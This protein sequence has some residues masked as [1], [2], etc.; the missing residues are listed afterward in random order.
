MA[1]ASSHEA[2]GW[3]AGWISPSSSIDKGGKDPMKHVI[4]PELA[5]Q[6]IS[7]WWRENY[8]KRC[9]PKLARSPGSENNR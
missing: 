2:P 9:E 7:N 8:D 1:M 4:R 6:V 5:L 3:L